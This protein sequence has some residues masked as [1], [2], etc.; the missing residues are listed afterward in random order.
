MADKLQFVPIEKIIIGERFRK[1][2]QDI[3]TLIGSIKEKGVIQPITIQKDFQLRAGGRRL[4]A[5]KRA[6]LEKI[7]CL[8][9]ESTDE[10]EMREIELIEN[11]FRQDFTWKER[12][13]LIAELD[14]LMREKHGGEW[15]TRKT[16]ALI[17]Q[18]HPMNVVRARQLQEGMELIPDLGNSK[19]A[20]EAY[21]LYKKFEEAIVHKELRRR[22]ENIKDSGL[23]DM[24][25]IAGKNYMI[26][27]ALKGLEGLR[28]NGVVNLIE[29]DPPYGIALNEQKK[30]TDAASTVISYNEVPE[31]EY[32]AFVEILA[33]ETYRVAGKDCW[34]VFWFGPTHFHIVRTALT[35]AGWEVDDI[36]AI[37]NKGTG[38]TNAP[39]YYLARAYEP[40]FICRKG[41]PVLNKR[42]RANV[43]DFAPVAGQK[44]Y[45]PT[46]RPIT[47]MMEILGTF[48]F[49]NQTVL[50]PFLGSGVTLRACYLYGCL[51]YGWDLNPEYKD[52]FLI[53]VEQDTKTLNKTEDE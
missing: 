11:T 2:L 53:E 5:A 33:E 20:D 34:M 14:R 43:F 42:G 9:M 45:H 27:D 19:T 4:E 23:K 41:R 31:A 44:K 39:E 16:A 8:I 1:D 32:Q 22:Q 46:E 49:P 15:S 26:G 7:P 40:F 48:T 28:D 30:K 25:G 29:V 18:S 24:L 3:E 37:W 21:K 38:Q 12:V 6:G 10:L 47:L 52:R 36:P 50:I 35:K 17:G 51:G 13:A